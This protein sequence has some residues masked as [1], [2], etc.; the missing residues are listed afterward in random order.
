VINERLNMK[1]VGTTRKGVSSSIW[2]YDGGARSRAN[3]TQAKH[4]G[5]A[6]GGGGLCGSGSVGEELYNRGGPAEVDATTGGVQD[7]AAGTQLG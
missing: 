1:R 2:F 5:C 3:D 7:V 4:S 6:N